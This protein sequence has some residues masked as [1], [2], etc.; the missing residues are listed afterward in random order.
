[1]NLVT[2]ELV[3]PK[4][5]LDRAFYISLYIKGVD[6]VL[7]LIGGGLLLLL[8]PAQIDRTVRFLAD[9]SYGGDIDDGVFRYFSHYLSHLTGGAIR[10]AAAYLI[11]DAI[12][13]LVL[14]NEVIHKRYW[15]YIGLIVVL[16]ALVVYQS[17]RIVLTHSLLLTALT[18]FDAVIIYLS[19]KEYARH[20]QVKTAARPKT[21]V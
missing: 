20:Q 6:G 13:K 17:Y 18:M 1:M 4:S 8:K 11:F 3:H 16:S 12:I 9:H 15:A 21:E 7:Q 14:I 10:F 2:E 5:R 19:A